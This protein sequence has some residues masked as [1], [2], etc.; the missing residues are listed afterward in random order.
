MTINEIHFI[1]LNRSCTFV[2]HVVACYPVYA[3][4]VDVFLSLALAHHNI[5]VRTY[6]YEL[7]GFDDD[8]Y[9]II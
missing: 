2:P 7:V 1:R 9:I 8:M 5:V 6:N 3:R 4:R